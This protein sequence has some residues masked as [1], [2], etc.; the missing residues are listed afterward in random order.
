MPALPL[1][2]PSS[3]PPALLA[4]RPPTLAPSPPSSPAVPLPPHPR[5]ALLPRRRPG[6]PL[7]RPRHP[8]RPRRL[9]AGGAPF[10]PSRLHPRFFPPT[11]HS[12]HNALSPLA[13]P[14]ISPH[15]LSPT[16]LNVSG[17]NH[18]TSVR[19]LQASDAVPYVVVSN[20]LSYLDFLCLVAVHGPLGVI[21]PRRTLCAARLLPPS[22]ARRPLRPPPAP[23]PAPGPAAAFLKPH[24]PVSP[25]I[26][27][28]S[29][30]ATFRSSARSSARGSPRRRSTLRRR[31]S[32]AA[33]RAR[34]TGPSPRSW[35][36]RRGRGPS[37]GAWCR[38]PSSP[39]S[40]PSRPR[41]CSPRL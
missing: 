9:G 12:L 41:W 18:V 7:L 15:T 32:P 36:S 38:S 30:E 14:P 20:H 23:A 3:R 33:S 13:L 1:P 37:A 5:R 2:A 24:L 25:R 4:S 40:T 21:A 34:G 29:P 6:V 28:V 17:H 35:P 8:R 22:A 27:P 11:H 31:S 19:R 26:S 10:P 39:G 16:Q